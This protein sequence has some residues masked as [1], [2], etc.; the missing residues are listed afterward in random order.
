MKVVTVRVPDEIYSE[1]MALKKKERVEQAEIVRR[2]LEHAI[3][4]ERLKLALDELREHKVTFRKAARI[5]GISYVE[6][7]SVIEEK[8]IDIGYTLSDLQRDTRGR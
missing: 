4:E 7:L 1:I 2:L 3:K 6:L 8:K 5:A